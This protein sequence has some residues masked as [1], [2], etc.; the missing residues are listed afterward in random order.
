MYGIWGK[1]RVERKKIME[2]KATWHTLSIV[3][4]KLKEKM[5]TIL[6]T[7]PPSSYNKRTYLSNN[8]NK[9]TSTYLSWLF[10]QTYLVFFQSFCFVFHSINLRLSIV[11]IT[12]SFLLSSSSSSS[13][14]YSIFLFFCKMNLIQFQFTCKTNQLINV[15]SDEILV[16]LLLL[17]FHFSLISSYLMKSF[18]RRNSIW[19][20]Y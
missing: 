5:K 6:A 13:S 18:F 1:K 17:L 8:N 20:R 4:S 15:L 3:I 2:Y 14:F 9:I 11:S 16:S 7:N 10:L 12:T 19:N